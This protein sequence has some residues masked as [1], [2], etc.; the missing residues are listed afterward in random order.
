MVAERRVPKPAKQGLLRRRSENRQNG[1]AI[2]DDGGLCRFLVDRV[3][4]E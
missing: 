1:Y 4:F 3:S 2:P